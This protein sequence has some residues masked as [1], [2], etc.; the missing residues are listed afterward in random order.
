MQYRAV[1]AARR[2]GNRILVDVGIVVVVMGRLYLLE[3]NAGQRMA[4]H[5]REGATTLREIQRSRQFPGGPWGGEGAGPGASRGIDGGPAL[6]RFLSTHQ[7]GRE[8]F[9]GDLKPSESV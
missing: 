7:A 8:V 1:G 2:E 4:E 5:S 6:S 3:A 9:K